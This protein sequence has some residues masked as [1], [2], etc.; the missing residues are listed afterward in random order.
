MLLVVVH[1][2]LFSYAVQHGEFTPSVG[3]VLGAPR[4]PILLVEDGV[5]SSPAERLFEGPVP[6]AHP[7]GVTRFCQDTALGPSHRPDFGS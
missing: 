3:V 2:A 1:S 4:G 5:A 6:T 7:R